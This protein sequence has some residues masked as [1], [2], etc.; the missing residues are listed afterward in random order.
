MTTKQTVNKDNLIELTKKSIEAINQDI[1]SS[2]FNVEFHSE[3]PY[4]EE[5]KVQ[6][7]GKA[8]LTLEQNQEKLKVVEGLLEKYLKLNT[9]VFVLEKE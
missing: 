6:A 7:V 5:Q 1:L 2:V 3:Y 8:M 4:E 9:D